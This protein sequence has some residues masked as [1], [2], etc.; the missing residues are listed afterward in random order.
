[1]S[2]ADHVALGHGDRLDR[3]GFG[4]LACELRDVTLLG[5][6]DEDPLHAELLQLGGPLRAAGCRPRLARATNLG[7]LPLAFHVIAHMRRVR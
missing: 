4:H 7:Q 2:H 1:M 3:D 6:L 5:C